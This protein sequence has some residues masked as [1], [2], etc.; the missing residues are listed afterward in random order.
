MRVNNWLITDE[1][2][3]KRCQKEDE[4]EYREFG[5]AIPPQD[6]GARSDIRAS[7]VSTICAPNAVSTRL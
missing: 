4:Y 5:F 2:R 7:S 1:C 6:R 3:C